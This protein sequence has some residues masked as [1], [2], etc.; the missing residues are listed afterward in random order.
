MPDSGSIVLFDL[1]EEALVL[2]ETIRGRVSDP[3]A[4]GAAFDSWVQEIAPS[5]KGWL[6]S[7]GGVTDDNELFILT[8]FESE[9]EAKAHE[10]RPEQGQFWAEVS[11]I[12]RSEP[13]IQT[14]TKVYFDT[15]GD[16]N[17]TGF[18]QIRLGQVSD[19]DRMLALIDGNSSWRTSRPDIL[20]IAGAVSEGGQ[21]TN[22][23]YFTS[24]EAASEGEGKDIPREVHAR[25]DEMMSLI[26]GELE[27]LDLK[28]PWLGW[29]K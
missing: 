27:Y 17:S 14:S 29:P 26:V 21:F 11:N 2:A 5:A 16:L 28:D 9:E 7:T 1:A 13:A 15:N 24:Y 6:G 20:G 22:A 23:V 19:G 3:K 25:G 8:L 4:M 18:V 10:S 12:F